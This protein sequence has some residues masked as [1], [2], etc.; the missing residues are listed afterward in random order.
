MVLYWGREFF[1]SFFSDKTDNKTETTISVE[2]LPLPPEV[3]L[4]PIVVEPAP[5]PKITGKNADTRR[6]TDFAR[7]LVGKPYSPGGMTPEGFDCSGFVGYVYNHIGLNLPRASGAL[8]MFGR[9]IDRQD[10]KPGDLLYFTGTDPES[11]Q[12]GHVAMLLEKKGKNLFII[13]ATN[14]GVVIDNLLRMKYYRERY[15]TASRPYEWEE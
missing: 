12:I 5:E 15:L 11:G 4:M 2:E 9:R 1:R 10:L 8:A 3:P 7:N 13:H 6:L 14:R